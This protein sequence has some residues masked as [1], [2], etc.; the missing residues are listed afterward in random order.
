MRKIK[1][2]LITF[3]KLNHLFT[4]N[5]SYSLVL[6]EVENNLPIKLS[7]LE[8]FS[9]LIVYWTLIY[10]YYFLLYILL[11][12]SCIIFKTTVTLLLVK[13]ATVLILHLFLFTYRLFKITEV[14]F[15]FT[16]GFMIYLMLFCCSHKMPKHY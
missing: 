2:I 15:Y 3:I 7:T 1:C 9:Y 14:Q 16:R 8:I 13:V 4:Q 12:K 10:S 5:K 6:F 11:F